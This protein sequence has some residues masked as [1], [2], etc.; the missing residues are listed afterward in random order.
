MKAD[1]NPKTILQAHM[2]NDPEQVVVMSMKSGQIRCDIA[3]DSPITGLF[4]VRI[5]QKQIDALFAA[6]EQS[7]SGDQPNARDSSEFKYGRLGE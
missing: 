5:L 7:P 4:Y 6:L 3:V 2:D 1:R